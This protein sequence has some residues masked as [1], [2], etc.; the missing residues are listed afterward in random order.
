MSGRLSPD[1][2]AAVSARYY[3]AVTTGHLDRAGTQGAMKY[4]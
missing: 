2:E 1:L 3:G 4:R